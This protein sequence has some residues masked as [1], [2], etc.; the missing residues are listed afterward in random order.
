MDKV[1]S[2]N[3]LFARLLLDEDQRWFDIVKRS[4]ESYILTELAM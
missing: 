2:L 3:H 4:Y 1:A